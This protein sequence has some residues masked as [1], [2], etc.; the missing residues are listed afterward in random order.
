MNSPLHVFTSREGG[1]AENGELPT[2]RLHQ[3]G[4][5]RGGGSIDGLDPVYL[6]GL[7]DTA[8]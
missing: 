5:R 1:S 7:S 3:Q 2:P 6:S 8:N 4:A